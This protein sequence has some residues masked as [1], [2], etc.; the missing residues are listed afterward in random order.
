MLYSLTLQRQIYS[1][2]VSNCPGRHL[3]KDNAF[4]TIA[5]ALHV[6]DVLPAWD[7]TGKELDITVQ[8][9]T[10]LISYVASILYV[11][12]TVADD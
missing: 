12:L 3:A 6:F 1:S 5:S 9:T 4:L 11:C 7:E 8:M 10:G 2:R